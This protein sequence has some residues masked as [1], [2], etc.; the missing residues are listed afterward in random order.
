[1]K[2]YS[3]DLRQKIVSTYEAGETSI[4]KVAQRFKV[5]KSTV[6]ELLKR[7]QETGQLLPRPAMGGRQKQLLNYK[8]EI[9]QMVQSY[10]DCTLAEYCEHLHFANRD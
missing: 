4:R 8:N 10:P 5:S 1:M 9:E 2:P 3:L 6:Q 7:K